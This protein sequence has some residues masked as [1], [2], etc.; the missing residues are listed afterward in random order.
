MS[1]MVDSV[2]HA[3]KTAIQRP[4]AEFETTKS[5]ITRTLLKPAAFIIGSEAIIIGLIGAIKFLRIQIGG[6]IVE[7]VGAASE[8]IV[9]LTGMII[10]TYLATLGANIYSGYLAR[11][12]NE[13]IL[14][15]ALEIN[16]GENFSALA[17]EYRRFIAAGKF[18]EARAIA[19]WIINRYPDEAERDPEMV[20]AIAKEMPNLQSISSG[21]TGALSPPDRKVLP[22]R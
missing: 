22:G 15:M 16:R 10:T 21:N 20:P 18:D 8:N 7:L 9:L 14:A 17:S 11:K 1:L 19:T 5:T 6:G 2:L 13:R 4:N 3:L 12:S